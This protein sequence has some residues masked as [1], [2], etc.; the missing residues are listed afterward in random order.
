MTGK[1]LHLREQ[2]L[3]A[4]HLAKN[5]SMLH[6][7]RRVPSCT[8]CTQA[9]QPQYSQQG[10]A[11]VFPDISGRHEIVIPNRQ[12]RWLT[13]KPD[14]VASVGQAHFDLLQGNYA[15]TDARLLRDLF[16]EHVIHKN[17][18][19]KVDAII[20]DIWDEI[21]DCVD[22]TWGLD[23]TSFKDISVWDNM[24]HVISRVSNRMFV[25]KPLCRNETFLKNN[26][27]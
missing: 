4:S 18:P 7:K 6:I 14:N 11:Y 17:L 2:P 16:H 9:H 23:T 22:Q 27:A 13:D 10:K 20:P 24:M 3:Q 21:K 8:I 25:G 26:A 5:G 12:L 15:F 19:R 1:R